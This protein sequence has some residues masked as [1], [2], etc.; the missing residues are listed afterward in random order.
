VREIR[1]SKSSW[2]AFRVALGMFGAGLVVL[3]L[4][5][6]RAWTLALP[7]TG[8][9]LFV[10]AILLP[11]A[12]DRMSDKEKARALGAIIVVDGG[13]YRRGNMLGFPAKMYVGRD[14]VRVLDPN[15]QELLTIPSEEI[16]SANAEECDGK[17]SL[18][19]CWGRE[20][21]L[22]AYDGAFAEHRAIAAQGA[23]RGVM[24]LRAGEPVKAKGRAASA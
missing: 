11:P 18:R 12:L 15:H 20:E 9:A 2:L 16:V 5:Y 8:L 24:G 3:P 4:G 21:A 7:I 6:G 19:I 1:R 14:R 17:W 10:A 23:V 13:D 22:F